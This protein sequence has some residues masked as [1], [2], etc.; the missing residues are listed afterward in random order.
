MVWKRLNPKALPLHFISV[1]RDDS[2]D[3]VAESLYKSI[4]ESLLYLIASGTDIAFAVDIYARYH[5]DPC[6]SHLYCAK[7]IL[8]YIL[9]TTNNSLWYAF[10]T[11]SVL[12]RYCDADWV[13]CSED[14]KSTPGGCFFLGNNLTAW[15]SKKHNSI[16]LSTVEAENI[17]MG[18][19]CT[20]LP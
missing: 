3:K 17:V 10:D 2:G 4:I 11:S 19:R 20:Q 15:L 1:S 16:S 8:K 18:T 6:F 7:H 9:G 14:C 12:V 5:S 13:R